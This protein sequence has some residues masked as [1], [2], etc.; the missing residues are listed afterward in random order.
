[1]NLYEKPII[2]PLSI[3]IINIIIPLILSSLQRISAGFFIY[4]KR[5]TG[6]LSYFKVS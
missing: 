5:K 1:M 3:T 4:I 6:V 2:I